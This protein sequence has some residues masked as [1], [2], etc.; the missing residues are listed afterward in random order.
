MYFF[1]R[2]KKKTLLINHAH[3]QKSRYPSPLPPSF[4]PG[5]LPP[6]SHLPA[7]STATNSSARPSRQRRRPSQYVAAIAKILGAFLSMPNM[8][9][10]AFHGFFSRLVVLDMY[11]FWAI[12]LD[13][14]IGF[15]FW[16]DGGL[17]WILDVLCCSVF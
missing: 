14:G 12:A 8:R 11:G 13:W 15:T 9:G 1:S 5:P 3:L 10:K 7:P 17:K 6:T 2:R 4:Q 16:G